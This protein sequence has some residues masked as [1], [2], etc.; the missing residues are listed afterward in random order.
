ML[1][2]NKDENWKLT[3]KSKEEIFLFSNRFYVS[4]FFFYWDLNSAIAS[5]D[6]DD[7]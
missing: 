5:D 6:D 3:G 7:Y 4:C 2:G 1:I